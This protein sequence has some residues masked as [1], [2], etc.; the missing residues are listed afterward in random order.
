MSKIVLGVAYRHHDLMA[1]IQ[2]GGRT[3]NAA[4]QAAKRLNTVIQKALP[5][6]KKYPPRSKGTNED[7]IFVFEVPVGIDECPDEAKA[8]LAEVAL[9]GSV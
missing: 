2:V 4:E 1:Y 5:L 9:D 7:G 8:F 3:E 6:T